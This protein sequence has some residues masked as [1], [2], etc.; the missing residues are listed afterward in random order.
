MKACISIIV[1]SKTHLCV[2]RHLSAMM[3]EAA[4]ELMFQAQW[5]TTGTFRK[6]ALS[7][8]KWWNLS[9]LHGLIHSIYRCSSIVAR[10]L[11]GVPES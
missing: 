5:H 4:T 1:C 8:I 11:L 7:W 10:Y 3:Y 2:L 6:L 9:S